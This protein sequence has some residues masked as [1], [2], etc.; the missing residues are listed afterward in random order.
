V[1]CVFVIEKVGTPAGDA[2]IANFAPA[3]AQ[4]WV[5]E[6]NPNEQD[7]GADD[8]EATMTVDFSDN[9]GAFKAFQSSPAGRDAHWAWNSEK[10]IATLSFRRRRRW[11]R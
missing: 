1:A 10:S 4:S 2:D 8:L 6:W 3:K 5:G 7:L 11:V 9:P